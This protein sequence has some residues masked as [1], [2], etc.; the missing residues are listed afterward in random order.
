MFTHE[1][2]NWAVGRSENL[3]GEQFCGVGIIF[4]LIDLKLTDLPKT[5][6]V[7]APSA[8]LL[9]PTPLINVNGLVSA[10]RA[11]EILRKVAWSLKV[12]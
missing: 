12:S 10:L 1:R 2:T 9:V 3:G 5:G 7:C 4:P 11:S 8:L 6:R